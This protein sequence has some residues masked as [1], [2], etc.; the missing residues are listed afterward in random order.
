MTRRKT[1]ALEYHRQGRPGKLA[2]RATKPLETQRDLSLAYSPGVAEPC[3][4]IKEDPNSV[5]DY[6]A[7]GNLVGVVSNGTAVLGLGNIG[8]EAGKPVMEGKAVLFK[9]FADIDCFDIE[10]NAPDPDTM[11]A[12]VTALEPT[13]GGINLED[14]KAP[15]CFYIEETLTE[16]LSIPVFHDDQHGT[17]II[18]T[19]AFRNALKLTGKKAEDVR[20]VYSGAGAAAIACAKMFL[21]AGVK[22]ENLIMCDSRGVIYTG[23]EAGMNPYKAR[24]AVDTE[25]RTLEEALVGA[26]V[27]VGV[28]VGGAVTQEMVK[29]MADQPI[30]FALANP[31][32]EITYDDARAARPNAIVATGRS[33]FPNQVNNVLGFPFIFRGALDVRATGVSDAMKLAAVDALAELAQEDVPDEVRRAYGDAPIT[34][35][36]DYI[37]PKP[38]DYRALLRVAPAVAR[39]AVESGVART[40]IT[41]WDAYHERLV[42]ILG[43]EREVMRTITRKAARAPI[44]VVYPEGD[45]PRIIR[46]AHIAM[47]EG[48]AKPILLGN[49]DK[50]RQV[51]QEVDVPLEGMTL[52]NPVRSEERDRYAEAL[53]QLRQRKGMSR[54]DARLAMGNPAYYGA[55]MVHLGEAGGMVGGIRSA[56]PEV[57]RPALQI[58]GTAEGTRKVCGA[59]L[60]IL[61]EGL[62]LFAD[63]TV[64]I[65]PD[66]ETLAE[67]AIASAALARSMDVDP[68]VAMLSFSNFGQTQHPSATRAARAVEIVKAQQPD[69]PI[70]GEIQASAAL[71][72]EQLQRLFPFNTL[73]GEANVLVFPELNSGNIAY[74]LM[75]RLADVDL[76]GPILMGMARPVNVLERDCPVR[77]IVNVTAITAVQAQEIA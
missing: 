75:G 38:F 51:A 33:D 18:A 73:G 32:P 46:A 10:L 62:K 25:H 69:L 41:D 70:D 9:R 47:E 36:P 35:G 64:N 37:I 67:I 3:I 56:Y 72:P 45:H 6:T 29:N 66:A 27:F 8:P 42:K 76:V 71:D 21:L 43:R 14:I 30:I 2:I 60:L 50:I 12:A 31:D 49:V 77:N 15:D 24:F 34:F 7:R 16:R 40:P 61:P 39:A 74:K 53:W 28:S 5:F 57:I 55:M 19:A 63:T 22:R 17:A 13:F 44:S 4:A 48:V 52:I 20:C 23:R 58:I 65:D 1:D 59:Y 26:D 11:I 54:A 68:R